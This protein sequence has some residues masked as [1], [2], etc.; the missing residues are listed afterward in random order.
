MDVVHIE[1]KLAQYAV[2]KHMHMYV[3][4]VVCTCVCSNKMDYGH[5]LWVVFSVEEGNIQKKKMIVKVDA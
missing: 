1:E 2:W 3:V 5:L 4:R